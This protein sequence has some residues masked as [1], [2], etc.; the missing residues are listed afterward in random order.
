M[1]W[2]AMGI[3]VSQ[4]LNRCTSASRKRVLRFYKYFL[5]DIFVALST[6]RMFKNYEHNLELIFFY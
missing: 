1:S 4:G 5:A 6:Y 3:D 2:N